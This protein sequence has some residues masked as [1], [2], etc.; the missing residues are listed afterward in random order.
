M[1][2][3]FRPFNQVETIV[4]HG[5]FLSTNAMVIAHRQVPWLTIA[6]TWLT[7]FII[8]SGRLLRRS[9]WYSQRAKDACYL[10]GSLRWRLCRQNE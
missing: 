10:H 2:A 8:V 1:H 7:R 9:H 3:S 6:Y 4:S 5:W